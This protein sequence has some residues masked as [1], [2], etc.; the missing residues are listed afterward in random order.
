MTINSL[1]LFRLSG[2]SIKTAFLGDNESIYAIN[3]MYYEFYAL[4]R[5][6][7]VRHVPVSPFFFTYQINYLFVIHVIPYEGKENLW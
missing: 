7:M 3:F 1:L 5:F 6:Y 4:L 2:M